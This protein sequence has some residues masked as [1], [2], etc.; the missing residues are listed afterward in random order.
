LSR[1]RDEAE[2]EAETRRDESCVGTG[3]TWRKPQEAVRRAK[4]RVKEI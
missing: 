2:A 3:R 4:E 1:E